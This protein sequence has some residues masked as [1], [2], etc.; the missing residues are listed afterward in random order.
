MWL[1][2]VAACS[3]SLS[4]CLCLV[5]ASVDTIKLYQ[6]VNH[7]LPQWQIACAVYVPVSVSIS[8]SL[9]VCLHRL[10]GQ[11]NMEWPNLWP[12]SFRYGK[13][14]NELTTTISHSPKKKRPAPKWSLDQL[15]ISWSTIRQGRAL[16]LVRVNSVQFSCCHQ[17]LHSLS[18]AFKRILQLLRSRRE[19]KWREIIST[20]TYRTRSGLESITKRE[21]ERERQSHLS[22]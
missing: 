20:G 2:P 7:G 5:A 19:S 1:Q 18:T 13:M 17:L 10:I 15:S 3:L 16:I 6:C 21:T 4:L 11:A 12:N 9:S 8:V 22:K 14:P